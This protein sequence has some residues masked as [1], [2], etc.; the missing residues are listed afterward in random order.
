MN[1][2]IRLDKSDSKIAQFI[3]RAQS[4]DESRPILTGMNINGSITACDGHR[5]HAIK[6]TDLPQVG[7]L[8]GLTVDIGKVRAGDNLLETTEIEGRYPDYFQIMP[9]AN[10]STVT[11]AVDPGFLVD[12]CKTLDKGEPITIVVHSPLQPVE[13]HGTLEDKPVYALIMPMHI[14]EGLEKNAWRP[15]RE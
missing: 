3:Q 10:E 5:L 7:Q 15:G 9:T 8:E 1:E 11:F 13:L 14:P 6:S 4:A 2:V 12:A